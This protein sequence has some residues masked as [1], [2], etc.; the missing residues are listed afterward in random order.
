[1][2]EYVE[3]ASRIPPPASF[4]E[5]QR[6]CVLDVAGMNTYTIEIDDGGDNDTGQ[7]DDGAGNDD[8]GSDVGGNDS[9]DD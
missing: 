8:D 1:M 3:Y 4:F 7:D 5:L 6:D 9:D 2:A